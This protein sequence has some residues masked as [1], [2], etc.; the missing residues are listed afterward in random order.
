MNPKMMIHKKNAVFAWKTSLK[1]QEN[2]LQ[3]LN[4]AKSIFSMLS[5]FNNGQK[6]ILLALFVDNKFEL[7]LHIFY[8]KFCEKY[9]LSIFRLLLT[10]LN[11][12]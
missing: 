10:L 2:K 11:N 5:A 4:A 7:C 9:I 1:T 12:K 3:N 6:I 8:L